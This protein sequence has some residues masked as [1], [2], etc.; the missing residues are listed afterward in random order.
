MKDV[1]SSTIAQLDKTQK[2]F[3]WKNKNPKLKHTTPCN[4]DEKRGLEKCEYF[5]QKNR[6]PMFVGQKT[7]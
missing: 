3:I 2:Q 6:S 7:T 5:F 1:P 4:K